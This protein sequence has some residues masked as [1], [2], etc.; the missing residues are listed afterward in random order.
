MVIRIMRNSVPGFKNDGLRLW[1]RYRKMNADLI[2]CYR[3]LAE[4]FV[5]CRIERV[6]SRYQN[7]VFLE[8]CRKQWLVKGDCR[9]YL[10]E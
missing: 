10:A 6:G 2:A 1:E 9:L 7:A 3:A 4:Q 5:R 8:R